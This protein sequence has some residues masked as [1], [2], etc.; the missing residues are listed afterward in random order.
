MMRAK[1]WHEWVQCIDGPLWILGRNGPSAWVSPRD[2]WP[3]WSLGIVGPSVGMGAQHEW[4]LDMGPG[5]DV[6]WVGMGPQH[7]W[8]L[9]MD[10]P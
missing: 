4:V 3:L 9:N 1:P 5:K 2:G 6:P 7:G 10:G 8:P